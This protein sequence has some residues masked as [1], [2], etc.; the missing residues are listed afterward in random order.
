MEESK[1]WYC[2]ECENWRNYEEINFTIPGCGTC[3]QMWKRIR[4]IGYYN[5]TPK[6]IKGL[7]YD[8]SNEII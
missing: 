2:W 8:I 6:R 3:Q 5:M 7:I 1:E 4:H